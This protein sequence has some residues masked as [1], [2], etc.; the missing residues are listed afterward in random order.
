MERYIA[1]FRAACRKGGMACRQF[2]AKLEKRKLGLKIFHTAQFAWINIL[3][4]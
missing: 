1:P 3:R 2:A 4:L